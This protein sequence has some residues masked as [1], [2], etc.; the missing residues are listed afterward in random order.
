MCIYHILQKDINTKNE[1]IEIRRMFRKVIWCILK[2]VK[3]NGKG[4]NTN[5]RS[6]FPLK[7]III[8]R[9]AWILAQCVMIPFV[10]KCTFVSL[11]L[12]LMNFLRSLLVQNAVNVF[13]CGYYNTIYESSA[14]NCRWNQILS[15]SILL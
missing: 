7:I 14:T 1:F 5:L 3:I 13:Q 12:L 15:A 10:F 8:A 11:A 4:K 9:N 2:G 6:V